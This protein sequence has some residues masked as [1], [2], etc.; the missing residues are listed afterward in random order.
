MKIIVIKNHSSVGNV[1][2]IK[3]VS[4]GYAANY[5]FPQGLAVVADDKNLQEWQKKIRMMQE[6]KVAEMVSAKKMAARLQK[7]TVK[8]L[9]KANAAGK[10]FG[11][12]HATEIVERLKSQG[13]IIEPKCLLMSE[14]LKTL[15]QHQIDFCLVDG[16]T[17][18]VAVVLE[19][20][21]EIKT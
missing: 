18:I 11:S 5:L 6:K 9:V 8:I 15:G 4:D 1:G 3:E 16:S 14:P 20:E 19:P 2:Q 17:G 12:V 7:A 21:A 13:I 10:V